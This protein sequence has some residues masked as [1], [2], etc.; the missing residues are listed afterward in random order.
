MEDDYS[1]LNDLDADLGVGVLVQDGIHMHEMFVSLVT[2][3]F[4]ED[5]ALRLVAMLADQV[6]PDTV[7]IVD[8][9]DEED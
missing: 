8:D 5:Q 7:F 2:A 6:G 4:T 3:G 9:G 1:A